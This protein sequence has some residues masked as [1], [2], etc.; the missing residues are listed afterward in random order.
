MARK[1]NSSFKPTLLRSRP[2][3]VRSR[4]HAVS[5]T[6]QR[7]LTQVL[8]GLERPMS[9]DQEEAARQELRS[10]L[11]A[12]PVIIAVA[13]ACWYFLFSDKTDQDQVATREPTIPEM[14]AGPWRTDIRGDITRTLAGNRARGCGV[15]VY[16]QSVKSS[17][18]FL[19]YCSPDGLKDWTAYQVWPN[20]NEIIGPMRTHAE[21]PPPAL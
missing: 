1:P 17:S 13:I 11:F 10:A 21:I 6:T 12:L 8:E 5:S 3:V 16:K 4:Y 7:G 20:I 9:A 19:V 18:E 14:Y 15:Y 2:G